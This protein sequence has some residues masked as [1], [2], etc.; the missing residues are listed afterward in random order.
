M[1]RRIGRPA[2][3]HLSSVDE[4]PTWVP[5]IQ[6]P[7]GAFVSSISGCYFNVMGFPI[8]KFANTMSDL[9]KD[10]TIKP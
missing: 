9:I 6:G 10:E 7:A 8:H 1:Q 2:G 4:H 3:V 5:C